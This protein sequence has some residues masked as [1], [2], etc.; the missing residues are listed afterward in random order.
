MSFRI[1]FEKDNEL[2]E[3]AVLCPQLPGCVSAGT[4]ADETR[5]NIRKAIAL[6]L[7]LDEFKLPSDCF[8]EEI[9]V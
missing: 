5:M 3:W 4:T 9:T 7:K 6:N 1:V 8:L 2:S